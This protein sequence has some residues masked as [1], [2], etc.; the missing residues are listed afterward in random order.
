MYAILEHYQ[1]A[2]M[3]YK[4]NKKNTSPY[5]LTYNW[6]CL[7]MILPKEI[8]C[9]ILSYFIFLFLPSVIIYYIILSGSAAQRGLWPH[10][11][12]QPSTGYGLLVT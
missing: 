3:F 9:I 4:T 11:A 5:C 10:V 12:L 2:S 7:I 1:D 6:G 8:H